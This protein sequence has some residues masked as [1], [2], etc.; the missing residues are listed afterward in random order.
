TW[1]NPTSEGNNG[2]N[3][4]EIAASGDQLPLHA[5]GRCNPTDC[6][7]GTQIAPAGSQ[8]KATWSFVQQAASGEN[9]RVAVVT[10]QPDNGSLKVHVL[11]TYAH[12][13]AAERDFEFV[14]AQ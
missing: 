3:K 6:D 4:L 9:G 10:L 11:N 8:V 5:W 14:R 2:I 13:P 1:T 7:W 12:R